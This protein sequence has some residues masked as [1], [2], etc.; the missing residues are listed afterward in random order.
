MCLLYWWDG[1]PWYIPESFIILFG[2]ILV[3]VGVVVYYFYKEEEKK[4]TAKAVLKSDDRGTN[5]I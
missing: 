2:F 1:E 4:P 5:L 3:F